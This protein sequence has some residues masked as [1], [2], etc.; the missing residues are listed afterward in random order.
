MLIMNDPMS[1]VRLLHGVFMASAEP[2][3]SIGCFGAQ[4][5]RWHFFEPILDALDE[6]Q[7]Y[8]R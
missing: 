7:P 1:H 2:C 6:L 5:R 4:L 8:N 3:N